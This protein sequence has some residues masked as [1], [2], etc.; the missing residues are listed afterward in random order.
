MTRSARVERQTKETRID[1]RL[2][3]DGSGLVELATGIGF[4]DHMLT[5][6]AHHAG[7]DLSVRAEGDLHVDGHHTVEDV[8]LALGQALAQAL[9]DKAGIQR[10]GS[11]TLPMD[12]V[13]ATV[14]VDLS[15]RPFLVWKA[16]IPPGLLGT[17]DAELGREF[18]QAL[19]SAARMNVHV[20]VHH[21]CNRHHQLE[22]IFKAAARALRQAVTHDPRATS[23][24][25][26]K[27]VL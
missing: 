12:D 13:L 8:G 3:L 15:G 6:L 5:H 24:P 1:L 4:F 25:S 20:V 14:A 19:A 21:G 27:G 17:F 10:F 22:A 18:W 26:T 9:G 11:C 2:D 7:W 23:I 16:D